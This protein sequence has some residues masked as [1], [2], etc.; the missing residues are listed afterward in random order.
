[1]KYIILD[2]ETTGVAEADRIIQ[3]AYLT[4]DESGHIELTEQLACPEQKINFHAMATHHITPEMLEGKPQLI[5]TDAYK[6][7]EELN[8][9]EN[10]IVIQNSEFDLKMLAKE[11]FK[12]KMKVIDTLILMRHLFKELESHAE[13]YARYAL[14][15]YRKEREL[16]ESLGIKEIAAHDAVGDILV[17]YLLFLHIKNIPDLYERVDAVPNLRREMQASGLSVEVLKK[18]PADDLLYVISQVPQLIS[19]FRFGKYKDRRVEDV[20]RDDR[21]YI[22]W[23]LNKMAT[24]NKDLEYTLNFYMYPGFV[25][26]KD[27]DIPEIPD[28]VDFI[29]DLREEKQLSSN[30]NSEQ[31]DL[32]DLF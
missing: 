29:P 4:V 16:A 24:L 5:K 25:S 1:M 19:H 7:L 22:D 27:Y 30:D 15:I 23:M 20:I 8:D 13:Q 17:L 31:P 12:N 26:E 3:L 32:F 21:N 9:P 28:S 6:K 10:Y 2:T 14:G 18:L 11:G